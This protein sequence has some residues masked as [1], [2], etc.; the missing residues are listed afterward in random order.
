VHEPAFY[1]SSTSD[2]NVDH[3]DLVMLTNGWRR[4]KWEDVWNGKTPEL[5]YPADSNYLSINGTIEG[6]SEKQS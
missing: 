3:L 2:S 6:L 1:F 5:L 4:F